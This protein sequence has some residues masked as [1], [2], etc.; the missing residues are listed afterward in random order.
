MS[1]REARSREA[2]CLLPRD[3]LT[4]DGFWILADET[5]VT[6]AQQ[7]DGSPPRAIVTL[8]RTIFDRFVDWYAREG[9]P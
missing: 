7:D 4:V 3:N 6:V 2:V 5:T 8:P 1:P 9:E